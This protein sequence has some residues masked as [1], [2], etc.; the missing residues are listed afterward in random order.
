M[1]TAMIGSTTI[2]RVVE[3]VGPAGTVDVI[4]PDS[5]PASWR[6]H[7][8]WLAPDFFRPEDNGYRVAL[9]SW[10]VRSGGTTVLVDT[11][12]G[13]GRSRPHMPPFDHLDNDYLGALTAAG[14]QPED[15]DL[16]VNTHLHVDHVGWN[17]RDAGGEWVPTFPKARYVLPRTELDFWDPNGV[18]RPAGAAVNVNVFED[19]VQPILD[20]GLVDA[21][22]VHYDIDENVRLEPAPGHTPGAAVVVVRSEGQS[23]VLVGDLLHSAAL[24]EAVQKAWTSFITGSDPGWGEH[25]PDDRRVMTIAEEWRE[26]TDPDPQR[27]TAWA[28][29]SSVTP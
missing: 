16:V 13:N 2:T 27:R 22:E 19:S 9:Q 8:S 5:D 17:T 20:A 28:A 15:V 23:A 10:L 21:W 7:R 1:D 25:R 24:V 11:G 3:W 18:A 12:A 4:V 6:E 14:V 26:N 29:L